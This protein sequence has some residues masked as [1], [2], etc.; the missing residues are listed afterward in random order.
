MSLEWATSSPPPRHN[1]NRL[2][3][4]RSERPAFDFHHPQVAAMD[5]IGLESSVGEASSGTPGD[6]E[7]R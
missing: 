6:H 7:Q 5:Q 3:R 4:I 2:P 1:F